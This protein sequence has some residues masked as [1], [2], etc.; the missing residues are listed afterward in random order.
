MAMIVGQEKPSTTKSKQQSSE[1]ITNA[2]LR[3]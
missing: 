1:L 3:Y 2:F